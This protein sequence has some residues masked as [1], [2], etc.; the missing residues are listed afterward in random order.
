MENDVKWTSFR[1]LRRAL[2]IILVRDKFWSPAGLWFF[3]TYISGASYHVVGTRVIILYLALIASYMIS[4]FK[5]IEQL[6]AWNKA[7][8]KFKNVRCGGEFSGI[9]ICSRVSTFDRRYTLLFVPMDSFNGSVALD[10]ASSVNKMLRGRVKR[11]D[12]SRQVTS[13]RRSTRWWSWRARG[14]GRSPWRCSLLQW[15]SSLRE[16]WR[17]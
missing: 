4:R 1:F 15:R 3:F 16:R 2:W 7:M 6:L 9:R 14:R 8:D 12:P 5:W 17:K 10:S 13:R 11:G